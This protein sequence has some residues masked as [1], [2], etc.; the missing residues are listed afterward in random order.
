MRTT[1]HTGQDT[2]THSLLPTL[3]KRGSVHGTSPLSTN[4]PTKQTMAASSF[5]LACD[6]L[7][8]ERDRVF[9]LRVSTDYNLPFAELEAKYLEEA[10]SAIKVPKV[11]KVRVAKVTVEGGKPEAPKCQA[12]TAKKGQCSFAALKG[13]CFCK[14]HLKQQNEPKQDVPKPVKPEPKKAQVKV[15]PVHTHE[16]DT[17]IH[18]DCTLCQTHGN[19]L[20]V[21]PV[22]EFEEAVEDSSSSDDE[23][24]DEDVTHA[25]ME[26]QLHE[27]EEESEAESEFDDE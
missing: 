21:A 16:I 10:E 15:D 12:L 14:R 11:K 23:E 1:G 19:P 7:A 9:L 3:N 8:R 20:E 24:D 13:E 6:A 26:A 2:K 5:A 18:P 22:K 25:K 4:Q 17:E 27:Y